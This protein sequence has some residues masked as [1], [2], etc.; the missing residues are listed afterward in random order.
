[1]ISWS[2]VTM[3]PNEHLYETWSMVAMFPNEHIYDILVYG[4]NVSWWALTLNFGWLAIPGVA[5]HFSNVF[6]MFTT[7]FLMD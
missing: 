3:I 4:R 5:V 6:S 1:M 2:M 7:Q